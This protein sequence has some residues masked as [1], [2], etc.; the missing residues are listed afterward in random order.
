MTTVVK[1]TNI[2]EL[3]QVSSG[4]FEVLEKMTREFRKLVGEP[5]G[6]VAVVSTASSAAQPPKTTGK[7]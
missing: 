3:L 4:N 7:S 5:S 6:K 1:N 2:S